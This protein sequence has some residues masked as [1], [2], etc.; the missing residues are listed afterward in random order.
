M[1]KVAVTGNIGS[2]KTTVCKVFETLGIPV[3]YADQEAKKLYHDNEIKAKLINRFGN[4]LFDKDENLVKSELANIIFNDAT[5]L[6]YVNQLIHPRVFEWFDQ[7][8]GQQTHKP[9][10]IQEA[11]LTFESGS[12]SRFDKIILVY[13]PEEQLIGRTMKRDGAT[14][15]QTI[16]RLNKQLPQAWKM[17]RAHYCIHNDQSSLVIPQILEIHKEL[18]GL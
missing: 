6:E 3:F 7:W 2:G 10:C 14:R 17:E 9:Y 8:S 11:A 18:T 5:A 15:E 16:S 13:A 1:L 12:Y 4:H